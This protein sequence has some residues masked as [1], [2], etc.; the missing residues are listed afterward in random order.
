MLVTL[1]VLMAITTV[2]KISVHAAV[3][4]GAVAML[5]IAYGSVMLIGYALVGG[6]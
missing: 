3:S 2:W 1:A 5:V 6:H 4:S